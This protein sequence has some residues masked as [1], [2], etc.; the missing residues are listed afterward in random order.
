MFRRQRS[1]SVVCV[2]C[3]YLVGVNDAQCYHCGRRHPGLWGFGPAL[4]SL[5]QDLGFVPF[6]TGLNIVVYVLMLLA[7]GGAMIGGNPLSFL[8]PSVTSLILFGAAGSYP[9]FTLGRWWTLL[10]ASWL[11]GSL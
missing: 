6:V 8:A 3:G 4:R 7:S 1:G 10:S 11:H 5:G 9:V 2:S